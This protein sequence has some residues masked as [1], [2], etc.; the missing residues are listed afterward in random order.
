MDTTFNKHFGLTLIKHFNKVILYLHHISEMILLLLPTES[1]QPSLS[2]SAYSTELHFCSIHTT[3]Y[4]CFINNTNQVATTAKNKKTEK[5]EK[6][7]TTI[8]IKRVRPR[9]GILWLTRPF[10]CTTNSHSSVNDTKYLS[11]SLPSS[12]SRLSSMVCFTKAVQCRGERYK[13]HQQHTS[14]YQDEPFIKT[15][16]SSQ[17]GK[18]KHFH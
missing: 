7:Y 2:T 17:C 12:L 8:S 14:L 10:T 18:A 13:H 6:S 15:W 11:S 3:F 16:S 4:I 1:T 9:K 5:K